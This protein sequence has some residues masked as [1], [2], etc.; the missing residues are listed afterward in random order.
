MQLKVSKNWVVEIFLP[1]GNFAGKALWNLHFVKFELA[2]W[3]I[4]SFRM[5]EKSVC[6]WTKVGK[7]EKLCEYLYISATLGTLTQP[8][9]R[10]LICIDYLPKRRPSTVVWNWGGTPI[11][12]LHRDSY[13]AETSANKSAGLLSH[14]HQFSSM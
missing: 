12:C 2:P 13:P 5:G 8:T 3:S 10:K 4:S 11:L 6:G 9:N 1:C 14:F 7:L